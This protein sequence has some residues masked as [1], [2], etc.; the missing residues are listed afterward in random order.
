MRLTSFYDKTAADAMAKVKEELGNDALIISS[1]QD[2]SDS[3]HIT[4]SIE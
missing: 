4:T 2:G 3:F 1:T